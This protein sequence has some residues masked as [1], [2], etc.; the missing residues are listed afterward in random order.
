ME[1][2]ERL[3]VELSS[4]NGNVFN[5]IGL[6]RRALVRAGRVEESEEMVER[7]HKAASYDEVL[8]IFWEYVDIE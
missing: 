3:K 2:E 8:Q 6:V 7:T 1:S 4:Q 5:L